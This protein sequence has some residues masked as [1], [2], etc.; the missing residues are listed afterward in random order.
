MG[1][2]IL[3]SLECFLAEFKF[4]Q[5]SPRCCLVDC[6]QL[7]SF[8]LRMNILERACECQEWWIQ[9]FSNSLNGW[10]GDWMCADFLTSSL[11]L[12]NHCDIKDNVLSFVLSSQ[13]QT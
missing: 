5:I 4:W 10:I 11:K 2:L 7:F 6:V 1:I 3:C 8:Q 9:I 13:S 12:T